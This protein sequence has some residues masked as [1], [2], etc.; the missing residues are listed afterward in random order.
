MSDNYDILKKLGKGSYG[1]CVLALCRTTGQKV[2]L[3]LLRKDKTP[4]RDFL[5][6]F[7]CSRLLA[8]HP[9]VVDTYNVAFETVEHFVFAQE[10]AFQGDLFDFIQPRQG[11]PE[12]SVKSIARQLMSALSFL[13]QQRY[14]HRDVKPENVLVMDTKDWK[15]KLCDFGMIL[16]T[17]SMARKTNNSIPY[18]PPEVTQAFRNEPCRCVLKTLQLRLPLMLTMFLSSFF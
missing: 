14:I 7:Q 17:G 16:P 11:L 8:A 1:T 4:Y 9:N 2:A 10:C 3:K 18:T 5:R 15:V 6:E 13:H 12:K